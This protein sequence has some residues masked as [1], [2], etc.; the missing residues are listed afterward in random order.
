MEITNTEFFLS[1]SAELDVVPCVETN[2]FTIMASLK[3]PHCELTHRAAIDLVTVI[4][5]SGSME[6]EKLKLVL[7]TLAFIVRQLQSK[8]K[9]AVVTYDDQVATPLGLTAMTS[10][11]KTIANN[12]VKSIVAGNCT[13]LCSGLLAGIKIFNERTTGNE[14]SSLLL[15]T[16]GLANAGIQKAP[17]IIAEIA[18]CEPLP[19]TI[20]TFGFGSDHDPA[21]LKAVSDKGNGVYSFITD[22]DI[23]ATAFAD[24]LGGLLSVVA[25]N[26]VVSIQPLNGV[27]ISK[28]NTSYK[29]EEQNGL[30]ILT[31]GDIQ[32]EEEKD[33]VFNI[34]LPAVSETAE[35]PILNVSVSYFDVIR[36]QQVDKAVTFNIHRN[37]HISPTI[38]LSVDRQKN[39][40]IVTESISEAKKL[41]D[42]GDITGGRKVVN[43]AIL[44]LKSSA[45]AQDE[46]IQS[47]IKDLEDCLSTL[48]D[49]TSYTSRGT[50]QMSSYYSSHSYQRANYSVQSYTNTTRRHMQQQAEDDF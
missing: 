7:Q 5:R 16:D 22:K 2:N 28:L 33:I 48:R 19:C 42:A 39:R 45:T 12:K 47:L 34:K 15:F 17:E 1:C 27:I 21:L 24:C 6:G 18:K 31:I 29:Y 32:S 25:Q 43:D 20:Y 35:I 50:Y 26:I 49:T 11:G 36:S 41:G 44:K 13:D 37:D 38:N 10:D 40:M 14:V 9:L 23:I 46:Y 30:I 3:A 4:D 8:D